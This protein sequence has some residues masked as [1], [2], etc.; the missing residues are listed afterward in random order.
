LDYLHGEEVQHRDIKPD[1]ILILKRHAKLGDFGLAKLQEGNRS[2]S[3]SGSGT[4]SYMPP[5]AWAGRLHKHSDQYSFAVT[6]AELRLERRLFPGGSLAEAMLKHLEGPG[7]LSPLGEAEQ[8]VLHKAMARDP[9]QRYDSCLDFVA[10]LEQALPE[11]LASAAGSLASGSGTEPTGV[12][13]MGRPRGREKESKTMRSIGAMLSQLPPSQA[14]PAADTPSS[15]AVTPNWKKG[16]PPKPPAPGRKSVVPAVLAGLAVVALAAAGGWA[17]YGWAHSGQPQ[18]GSGRTQTAEEGRTDPAETGP[19]EKDPNVFLPAGAKKAL[20]ATVVTDSGRRYYNRI[21]VPLKGKDPTQTILIPF[22]FVPRE[23]PNQDEE[24]Q[25]IP[26]FYVMVDKVTVEQFKL[27]ATAHPLENNA[28]EAVVEDVWTE[29]GPV[30]RKPVMSVHVEDAYNFANSL[31]GNL[32]KK[33][34][35]DKAAGRYERDRGAGPFVGVWDKD[36]LMQIGLKRL[37]KEGPLE[38]GSAKND[39]SLLGCRDMAG[40]GREWTRSLLL[41]EDHTIPLPKTMSTED[42]RQQ[43]VIVRGHSHLDAREPL[44]FRELSNPN[45]QDSV[46]WGLTRED[47][48]FRVVIDV[49][50]N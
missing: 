34:Q 20:N 15:V 41:D 13:T 25:H 26:P 21:N 50:D 31:H 5:E 18:P 28:W 38:A 43:D 24:G 4:P 33:L 17:W 23:R 30:E 19:A 6:Y 16:E 29:G 48:G 35:W 46:K 14:K 10:A 22:V 11:A 40:N 42:K 37:R 32:P 1:N 2:M 9:D 39:V 3:V 27:F 47:V 45:D 44:M 8:A 12:R 49:A 36:N 7:D